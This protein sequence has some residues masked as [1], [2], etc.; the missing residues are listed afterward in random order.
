MRWTTYKQYAPDSR[1]IT[2]PTLHHSIFTGRMLLQMP[3]QQ[4][5]STKGKLPAI[6][7]SRKTITIKATNLFLLTAPA[8]SSAWEER[9]FV[10]EAFA[11]AGFSMVSEETLAVVPDMEF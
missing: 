11:L 4:C 1:Q 6:H 9:F 5:W 7:V 8:R 10:V 3:K 2:K